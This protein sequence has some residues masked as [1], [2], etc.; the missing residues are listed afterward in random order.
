MCSLGVQ[1]SKGVLIGLLLMGVSQGAESAVAQVPRLLHYQATL[2]EDDVPLTQSTDLSFAFYSDSTGG[3]PLGGWSETRSNVEIENGRVSLLLGRQT[4]LPEELFDESRL[5]LEVT[6]DDDALPRL[7]LASTAY[8]LQAAVADSVSSQSITTNALAEGAVGA[9]ALAPGAVTAGAIA[10]DA[11][12]EG[13]L[14]DGAVT[15]SAL[16]DGA[17]TTEVLADRAVT[18][19]KLGMGAV[20]GDKLADGAVTTSKLRSEAL[21]EGKIDDGQVV[22]T[23]NSLTDEVRLVEG[24]DIS[25][26]TNEEEGTIRIGADGGLFSSRR[27]KTDIR[28]LRKSLALVQE[29]EGVRYRWKESGAPDIGLIAEE[30][31]EVVPELVTYAENGED[32]E[33][34]D[35]AR[36]VAVLIEAIKK[37]QEQLE[38]ERAAL[39]VLER[40]I[41]VLEQ[42]SLSADAP[43]R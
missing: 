42:R 7:P 36:L 28:P 31:G 2:A 10:D 39:E 26:T 43:E 20:A 30:V 29:L 17:V 40:R 32:A 24:N 11:V 33:S 1:L 37:Q 19:S 25:I 13:A 21:T 16:A 6:V 9:S 27:W 35:Y 12:T 3:S 23:L 5:Y 34:V 41:E 4:P 15:L 22:K 8:A 38:A 14:A 18:S